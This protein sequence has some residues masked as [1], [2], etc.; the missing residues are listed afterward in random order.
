MNFYCKIYSISDPS[1][2][3]MS[4]ICFKYSH[5]SMYGKQ[6]GSFRTRTASSS[7]V[8]AE[9][10]T[11]LFG[12]C[13]LADETSTDV[14]NRAAR[15]NYFCQHTN[16][17]NGQNKTYILVNLSWFLYHPKYADFGKPITITYLILVEFILQ[18][19]YSAL[20]KELFLLL[21]S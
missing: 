18:S 13:S 17:I 2:I 10:N 4:P 1:N 7:V 8:M 15:I 20:R 14:V 3:T 5:L 11:D 21:R 9:W 19:Q 12:H 16:T 6:L